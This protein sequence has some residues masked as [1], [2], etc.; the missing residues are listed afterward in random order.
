MAGHEARPRQRVTKRREVRERY[1]VWSR[2]Q[3]Q[4]TNKTMDRGR[5]AMVGLSVTLSRNNERER[6]RKQ[7]QKGHIYTLSNRISLI[8]LSFAT[9]VI[10]SHPFAL[11]PFGST[12]ELH[13]LYP[14]TSF[15]QVCV[16]IFKTHRD[17]EN[18][19]VQANGVEGQMDKG[20]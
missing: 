7:K 4:K 8:F 18:I 1:I 14:T 11:C 13:L 3:A 20:R 9:S 5:E 12:I 6:P 19:T 15:K 17:N 10:A 2:P 16:C